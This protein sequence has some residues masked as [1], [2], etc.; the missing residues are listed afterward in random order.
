MILQSKE[1]TKPEILYVTCL[2]SVSLRPQ[3]QNNLT[4]FWALVEWNEKINLT[5]T[6]KWW[7][8]SQTFSIRLHPFPARFRFPQWNYQTAWDEA[9]A[10]FLVY[11]WKSLS[12]VKSS[13]I[14]FSKHLSNW[15]KSYLTVFI[16][17]GRR[18]LAQDKNFRVNMIC[19]SSKRV[20]PHAGFIWI[21]S[22][23]QSWR[24]W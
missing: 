6:D 19:N 15:L 7:S 1:I 11:Q 12:S 4:L 2:P 24:E 5:A 18:R 17:H 21:D 20:A 8:L 14:P 23:S 16:Y 9:G 10:G 13:L 22:S 3:Q